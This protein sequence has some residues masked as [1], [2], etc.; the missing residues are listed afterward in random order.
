[1]RVAILPHGQFPHDAKTA[2]G[3]LRY[4]DQDVASVRER[5]RLIHA[6]RAEGFSV[7]PRS[8]T[9]ARSRMVGPYRQTAVRLRD[10]RGRRTSR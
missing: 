1:M 6:A 9:N 7:K 2:V 10:R 3:I 5:V 8:E 4:G